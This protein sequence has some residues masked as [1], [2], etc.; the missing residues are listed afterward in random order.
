MGKGFCYLWEEPSDEEENVEDENL[1]PEMYE[2]FLKLERKPGEEIISELKTTCANILEV[3][4]A[5]VE[6]SIERVEEYLN[7]RGINLESLY[8]P[9]K[10]GKKI[11][12]GSIRKYLKE[13]KINFTPL[14]EEI[15]V[16]YGGLSRDYEKLSKEVSSYLNGESVYPVQG[17]NISKK[18]KELDKCRKKLM[19]DIIFL[20]L[21]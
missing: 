2:T 5:G 3:S 13:R 15:I 20:Y 4:L 12:T 17:L 1:D 10:D 9:I 7:H 19:G 8:K 14:T 6:R 11:D 16:E 21:K 18:I